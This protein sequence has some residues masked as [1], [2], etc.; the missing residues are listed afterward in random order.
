M[1]K[2]TAKKVYRVEH[3]ESG[4]GP[5][6]Y[7]HHCTRAVNY[8]TDPDEYKNV[9]KFRDMTYAN[10]HRFGWTTPELL[11]YFIKDWRLLRERGFIIKLLMVGPDE[12]I[13]Y[14]DGQIAFVTG[15]ILSE[16][17]IDWDNFLD[18]HF[19]KMEEEC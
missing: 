8:V 3:T 15:Q 19:F 1:S 11:R 9:P 4:F 14:P 12:T 13:L 6:H 17:I 16:E 18:K 2:D 7:Q 5:Y 10:S